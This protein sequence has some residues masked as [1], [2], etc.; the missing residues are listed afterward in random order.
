MSDEKPI[1]EDDVQ[2]DSPAEALSEVADPE[3]T[4]D[5]DVLANRIIAAPAAQGGG[6]VP[7]AIKE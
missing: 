7:I 6:G 3:G 2:Q 1:D 4:V 5:E